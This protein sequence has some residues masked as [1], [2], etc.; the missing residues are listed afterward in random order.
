[1]VP[2]LTGDDVMA[3]VNEEIVRQYFEMKGYL[4]RTR[5]PFNKPK[6]KTGK[7]SSGYGDIDLIIS[8]P[9]NEKKPA[10]VGVSGWHMYKMTPSYDRA[11]GHRL[12]SFVSELAL[13]EATK[14]LGT[15]DFQK[16]LVVSRMGAKEKSRNEFR[17]LAQERGVTKVI[18]F[19]EIID[20]LIKEVDVRMSPDS[21]VVQVIRILKLYGYLP[22]EN[23]QE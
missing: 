15:D 9:K 21:E 23:Q 5:V 7:K 12:F 14:F 22:T 18:T 19:P 1:M 20:D 3:D 13:N 10:I 2:L 17:R 11:L 8:D 4:V 16:I 6:E